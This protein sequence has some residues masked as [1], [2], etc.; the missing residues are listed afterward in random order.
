MKYVWTL[1]AFLFLEKAQAQVITV[2]DVK[3]SVTAASSAI[4]REQALDQAHEIAFH[5]LLSENFSEKPNTYLSHDKIMNMVT[6]FSIDREKSTD[7]TYTASLTFQFDASLIQN[8][9]QPQEILPAKKAVGAAPLV[10]LTASYKTLPQWQHIKKTLESFSSIQKLDVQAFSSQNATLNITC[11]HDIEKLQHQLLAHGL[12]LS[13]LGE[14][15]V[16]SAKE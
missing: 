1:A 3:V 2:S 16:I 7:K 10:K 11:N 9:L 15:W 14:G 12:I 5:K 6:N 13:L 4:A 8:W